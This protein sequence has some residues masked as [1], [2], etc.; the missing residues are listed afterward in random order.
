MAEA[1]GAFLDALPAERRSE[2]AFPFASAER[3]KWHYLPPE[4][5]PRGGVALRDL[6]AEQQAGARR[7]LATGL[8]Q[9]GLLTAVAIMELENVIRALGQ[10]GRF[11]RD[12]LEYYVSVFGTPDAQGSWGWRF[13]GHHLSLHFTVVAG[14]ITVST[15]T[16][17]GTNPAEMREGPHKGQRPLGAQED[18]ARALAQSLTELQRG[19]GVI[20]GA[21]PA[22][23]VTAN[24]YPIETLKPAGIMASALTAD[25]QEMLKTLIE[26]HASLMATEIAAVRLARVFEAGL[27]N[28]G[29]AWAGPME[30]G[31]PHYYRVQ[32]P[33]F[34]IEYDNTQND[35]NH[36]HAVW[37][38]FSGDFGDD[39]LREHYRTDTMHM[40][41]FATRYTAAWCSQDP[42]SVAA[43]FTASGSLKINDGEP[44]VGRAAI[45]EAARGF[46]TDFPDLAVTM[47]ALDQKG[48]HYLYRWTLAGTNTG[49]GGT[50]NKVRISGYEEWTI[51]A[52]GL[53]AGSLGHYDAADY[54]RQLG[55]E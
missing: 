23:I 54:E 20:A 21:A 4:M 46:M 30:P 34:L 9:R 33:G 7:L 29:F 26:S 8:G 52:D 19:A 39:L 50:G 47:D 43:F 24:R 11:A 48:G 27:E 40:Q 3:V 38:D 14:E 31:Q 55:K 53:I 51:G 16:F 41:D 36:V 42:E 37:R 5:F 35:A 44:S 17:M 1:A 13:E 15:P 6:N 45:T 49:P 18:H 2:A 10:G 25:Q 22:E 32:G 12:A 28:V